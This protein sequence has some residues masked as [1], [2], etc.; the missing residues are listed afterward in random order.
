[1]DSSTTLHDFVLN[2]LCDPTARSAFELDPEGAL[3]AAGLG[4]IT[5]ADVQ[6]VI[7]LVVD[8]AP[9][10]GLAALA[11]TDQVGTVVPDLD[12]AGAVRHL[13]AIT[14]EVALSG[15]PPTVDA[16]AAVASAVTVTGG[17]LLGEPGLAVTGVAGSGLDLIGITPSGIGAAAGLSADNDPAATVDADL[18]AT[19]GT[20]VVTPVSGVVSGADRLVGDTVNETAVGGTLDVAVNTVTGIGPVNDL[21]DPLDL[22]GEGV[23]PATSSVVGS[24]VGPDG[25]VDNLVHDGLVH[26]GL[27]GVGDTVHGLGD[28]VGGTVAGVGGLIDRRGSADTSAADRG[29]DVTDLLF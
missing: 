17:G 22:D 19:V 12:L 26:D 4:D 29:D 14:Q 15:A 20:E 16:T 10:E 2:L 6:E 25:T 11:V 21:L 13:Q 8:Y 27:A 3:N 7:P 9:V 18:G 24:V 23:L 1:M 5:A 28:T